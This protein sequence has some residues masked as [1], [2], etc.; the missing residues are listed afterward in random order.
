MPY[1]G[2]FW[3][4]FENN[5][6]IFE[7]STLDLGKL[8]IFEKKTK[9]FEFGTK[10]ALF[11]YFWARISTLEFVKLQNFV[12][13]SKCV[14]FEPKMT[15]LSSFGLEFWN[16]IAKFEICTLEFVKLQNFVKKKKMRKFGT[17]NALFG[18]FGA[19]I[20]KNYCHAWNQHPRICLIAKFR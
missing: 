2:I 16:T 13:K 9:M 10:N 12:K 18:Y 5:I 17:K 8:W 11:G 14:N 15:Y 7:I 6:V 20:L 1:L 3:L 19:G 4:E